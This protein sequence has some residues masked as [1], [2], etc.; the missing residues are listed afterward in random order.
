MEGHLRKRG[1]KW[2]YSFEASNVDGK[3]KRI[4]RVGGNTKKEAEAALRTALQNYNNAGLLLEPT[5]ISYSDYLDYWLKNYVMI[6]C[7][8]NTQ[9]I[10][11]D[12][13]RIHLK[14]YLGIYKVKSITPMVLQQHL[15]K[16]Y[17]Q[18]LSKNYL[19]NI[20]GVLSGSFN[21]AVEPSHM[22][23]ENPMSYVKM[24][25]CNSKKVETDHK[26]ISKKEFNNI[27]ERFPLGTQYYILLMI[28][29]YTGTRIA[30]CTGLTWDKVDLDHNSIT[31]NR[32]LVKH[33]D[34]K[35]YFGDPKTE[36]SNR[37]IPIGDTLAKALR[38]HRKIQLQNRLKY[39][40]YY[41]QY[42]LSKDGYVYG[43]DN[44][45]EYKTNDE[46]IDFVCCQENGTLV[47]PDLAR[48]CSRVINYELGIQ[49]NFHSLRHTHATI[50]IESG[51][52]MKDV[53]VRLGHSRIATTMDTYVEAT[54]SMSKETVNIFEK[55]VNH[56]LPTT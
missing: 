4:E 39:G 53:Q 38:E 22:I 17:A 28:C 12:I 6:E 40:K 20:Y 31:I 9:R 26:I 47:N 50:L 19:S 46:I 21:Y 11:S 42:Y 29:Y 25:K 51:A 13:I 2:Y 37:V 10:Y 7:R 30:E 5:E 36:T 27:I 32:I 24:P 49:F 55:A 16:L 44:V 41:K 33:Q 48:Y 18:G 8:D 43:L 56:D 14:P 15:N 54:K 45:V 34:K 35:W 52:N 23:R 1:S 3:R